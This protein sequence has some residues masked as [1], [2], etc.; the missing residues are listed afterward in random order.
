MGR[1]KARQR[2]QAAA[3]PGAAVLRKRTAEALA[4]GAFQS[5][6]ELA[7]ALYKQA[8]TA[9]HRRWLVEATVGRAAQLRLSGQAAEAA[10]MLRAIVDGGFD[11][12]Q[13]L[14]Q[15]A[16]ELILLG[17]GRTAEKLT[18]QI[19]D[20]QVLQGLQALR[21][22]AAVLQGEP[23]LATLPPDVRPG[24]QGVLQ[25]L[26]ALAQGDDTAARAAVADIPSPSP[27]HDWKLLVQ[28]LS[29]FYADG[30][31]ALE[32]WQQLTPER[33]PAAIAAPF[34]AQLDPEFLA[35][36]PQ[37][38]QAELMAFGQRLHAEA[39][40]GALEDIRRLLARGAVPAALRRAGEAMPTL[41]S[42]SQELRQRLAR[43]LYWEVA[44][45]GSNNELKTYVRVFGVPSD[46]PELH[47]L[48]ALQCE[49]ADSP[50][51]A[52]RHWAAYEQGL[53]QHAM[54]SATDLELARSLVWLHMGELAEEDSPPMPASLPFALPPELDNKDACPF[55]A[56]ECYRRSV[57]LAPQHLQAHERLLDLLHAEENQEEEVRAA[58]H[59]LEHFPEH[60]RALEALANE[61]FRQQRWDE[62][63]ALQERAVRARPHDTALTARLGFYR[64]GLARLLAQQGQFEAARTILLA[65]LEK[66]AARER[67]SVLCRL[68]AVELKAGQQQRGEELFGQACQEAPSRLVAVFRMLIESTRMPLDPAWTRKLTREFRHGLKGK[69]DGPS[70]VAM[71]STLHA[72]QATGVTYDGLQEHQKLVLQYLKRARQAAFSEAELRDVC[73]HLGALRNHR[74]LLDFASRGEREFP[75]QP[76][77]PFAVALSHLSLGPEKCPWQ[78]AD[79]ALHRA[80]DLAQADPAYADLARQ[81]E[82]VHTV[83]ESAM[84]MAG[85]QAFAD[86]FGLDDD[87]EEPFDVD[88]DTEE[89]PAPRRGRGRRTGHRW[90]K[91]W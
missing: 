73:T 47:R 45:R 22:D 15:C 46:D 70:A 72:F 4:R 82:A 27:L 1:A 54:V 79:A 76:A 5:A 12:P 84:F 20:A 55:P 66:E 85:M 33:A 87:D 52:Q 43:T 3:Q 71:L 28:G 9:E 26:A 32:P 77:F 24:A 53:T 63:V 81:V 80:L 29:A 17:D 42:E 14:A 89:P 30:R 39:W 49:Q 18:R 86:L 48:R 58:R 75:H 16:R 67:Y 74:L 91:W 59:L 8:P 36:H 60:Q 23:G 38:Q 61:A 57:A 37:P 40:L 2:R 10:T 56:S 64:L 13:L 51:A 78:K 88:D 65:Q 11:A 6:R 34:R 90:P 35:R 68:A 7:R 21:V 19:A 69:A 83:V 25:A 31:A 62:A 44:R 50:A 41:P